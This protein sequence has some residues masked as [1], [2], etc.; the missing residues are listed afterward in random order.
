MIDGNVKI[1]PYW[2]IKDISQLHEPEEIAQEFEAIFVRMI[3]KEFRKSLNNGL[4]SS[5]FQSKMYLDMFDMQ[6]AEV[7]ASSGQLGL[8]QYILNALQT[9]QKYSSGD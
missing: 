1:R 7:V 3:M 9:Y 6:I 4:F 8:K 2:D 5:S